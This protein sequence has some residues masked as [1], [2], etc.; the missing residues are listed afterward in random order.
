[1]MDANLALRWAGLKFRTGET[2]TVVR[3]VLLGHQLNAAQ[4]KAVGNAA[5][6]FERWD[7]AA[8]AYR[9]AID[10]GDQSVAT[11]NNWAWTAMQDPN[12]FDAEKI[13]AACQ[14]A[15]T[16]APGQPNIIETYGQA[17][18]KSG[19]AGRCMELLVENS[20]ATEKSAELSLLQGQC[21][22]ALK[23]KPSAVASLERCLELMKDARRWHLDMS[24]EE[25]EK[26][27]AELK[28]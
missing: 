15:L 1:T 20:E 13:I 5:V 22:L 4:W 8:F 2:G 9:E 24:R 21:Y 18:L 23:A 6:S 28:D 27:I 25:I 26:L 12:G 11:L 14:R 10:A 19:K 16:V 17:L 3:D 7:A